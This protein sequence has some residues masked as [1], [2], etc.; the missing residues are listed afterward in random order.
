MIWRLFF[1]QSQIDRGLA[2]LNGA[3]EHRPINV[4]ATVLAY[5]PRPN[6]RG[7]GEERINRIRLDKAQGLLAGEA[8][9]HPSAASFHALG[10]LYLTKR[11]FD[12]A[13]AQ[14]EKALN[15]DSS[16]A[17]F[18]SDLGAA[19]LERGLSLQ[20]ADTGVGAEDLALAL[21]Y[22]TRGLKV[23]PSLQDALFNLGLVHES[24]KLTTKAREDWTR[25]LEHDST[26]GWADEARDHLK[27]L[28]QPR[29]AIDL[30]ER[31]HKFVADYER[32]DDESAWA[33]LSRGRTSEGNQ[34]V[35][36]LSSE[37]LL[38][39]SKGDLA[40]ATRTANCLAYAGEIEAK[41]A[42]DAYTASL[43]RV[44]GS[45]SRYD[46]DILAAAA[47]LMKRG[48]SSYEAPRAT[49]AIQYYERAKALFDKVGDDAESRYVDYRLGYCHLNDSNT[50]VSLAIFE[51]LAVRCERSGYHWLFAQAL[52]S[53][54]NVQITLNNYESA[55]EISRRFLTLSK[56]IDDAAGVVKAIQQMGQ[57][58]LFLNNFHLAL[59][60]HRQGL[61]T[62][63]DCAPDRMLRWRTYY[64]IALPLH[65]LG[66]HRAAV[67]YEEEALQ[68]AL[69]TQRPR[70]ICRTYV[71]LGLM[72]GAAGE[73]AEALKNIRQAISIAEG[74]PSEKDRM[75]E[76]AY[77]SLQAGR[78]YNQAG[79]AAAARASFEKA[80]ELYD[81]KSY[82]AFRYV[83]LK[84]KVLSCI[85]SGDCPSI[86]QDIDRAM[87]IFEN[88][89]AKILEESNRDSF[90]DTEQD[91]YDVAID[92]QL[93]T[94]RDERKAFDYA[95]R[96]RSRSLLD[97]ARDGVK[98]SD[99]EG[100]SILANHLPRRYD[101]LKGL[102][103]ARVQILEYAVLK[104]K[105]VIWLAT[106]EDLTAKQYDIG[107]A[108]LEATVRHY[109]DLI[110]NPSTVNYV[111]SE[112]LAGLLY[113]MLI[114]PI[115]K[116]LL[117]DSLLCLIPDRSLNY[118]PFASLVS[119]SGLR[120]IQEHPLLYSPSTNFFLDSTDAARRKEGSVD[121]KALS[122]GDPAFDRRAFQPL[123]YLPSARDEAVSVAKRYP[124]RSVCL[125]GTTATKSSVTR[126]IGKFDV[127]NIATH[128]L[129]GE[130][131]WQ[132]KLLLASESGKSP[133]ASALHVSEIASMNLDR[134]RLVSLAA[135][136]TA[137]GGPLGETQGR[138]GMLGLS[139]AFLAAR[140][141]L[142]LATLWSVNSDSTATLMER[143]H[144]L[145]KET[146]STVVALQKAQ[147]EMLSSADPNRRHPYYW[148]PF[149]VTG[150]MALF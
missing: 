115:E 60:M 120:L 116:L 93:S 46:Q 95:E 148:A 103:P 144:Q 38:Q 43:A 77:A 125:V 2:A 41:R 89:R 135:C 4:R 19:Y 13:I 40:A 126:L 122:V 102:L 17:K 65:E 149:V 147:I 88:Y 68:L 71:N 22:L 121:E 21:E 107:S 59:T 3:F 133:E 30:Q 24:M 12:S 104:N 48:K 47:E 127:A 6:T 69:E 73:H 109:T 78:L 11:E 113:R 106:R 34:I 132:A 128:A 29:G 27:R 105:L 5:L 20:D 74:I 35:Q 54:S 37:C 85:A 16:N 129:N 67:E 140:A 87:D 63:D 7:D 83:A 56:Q 84:G 62:V 92:Y 100:G 57:A 130:R 18:S 101:E 70:T 45:Q 51:D 146:K 134:T 139:R 108:E 66:F 142:V 28:E 131:P 72:L 136:N 138:E 1:Y 111:E 94:A 118:V 61:L 52:Y 10:C 91:V 145:R 26:S 98:R 114:G 44:Y 9:E 99:G 33:V 143:F 39:R 97:L 90:F 141:P 80:S 14:L 53:I 76:V 81:S 86:E 82:P 49:E 150:G 42:G 79:D 64:Y 55:V 58:Y 23:N 96:S 25:Y 50:D 137:V 110:T 32:S 123:D 117:K 36:R 119:S 31:F 112:R 15:L 75:Q 124:G 8:D